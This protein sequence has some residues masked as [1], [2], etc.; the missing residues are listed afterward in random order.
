MVAYEFRN[1]LD[2]YILIMF[3]FFFF[4]IKEGRRK[5]GREERKQKE[6]GRK[7]KEGSIF[8]WELMRSLRNV[9]LEVPAKPPGGQVQEAGL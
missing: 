8:W 9:D 3:P 7:G 5:I 6:D 2:S 1:A 4:L